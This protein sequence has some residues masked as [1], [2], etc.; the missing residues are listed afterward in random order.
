MKKDKMKLNVRTASQWVVVASYLQIIAALLLAVL[1]FMGY[2]ASTAIMMI[3]LV[4][5]VIAGNALLMRNARIILSTREALK[6]QWLSMTQMLD[7]EANLNNKLRAQRHDFLNHL[8]VVSSLVQLEE[9]K[10]A[11]KYLSKII[12]DIRQLGELL[13]T[14]NPAV[15]ALLAAKS[16][17]AQKNNVTMKFHVSAKLK[18]MP[19]ED[20]QF[21]RILS[22]LID[23]AI[24]EAQKV[25]GEVHIS[26]RED[27]TNLLFSVENDGHDIP[28]ETQEKIFEPGYTTKGDKGTGMGLY[29]V[30][31]TLD[32]NNGSMSLESTEGRTRF[33]GYILCSDKLDDGNDDSVQK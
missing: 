4:F 2:M 30:Q 27:D 17:D 1:F 22:N 3:M 7:S 13:K 15:N 29:I 25:K 31:Q 19:I 14:A 33:Y 20:W 28:V 6:E 12:G 24:F 5:V 32:E 21:C 10:E 9:Y 11:N 18:N 16:V 26:L 8:Q 23:N